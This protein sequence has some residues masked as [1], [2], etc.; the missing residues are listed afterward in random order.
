MTRLAATLTTMLL[1]AT[2]LAGHG[3]AANS[4]T[5][6]GGHGPLFFHKLGIQIGDFLV[7]VIPLLLIMVPLVRLAL[8]K[9]H[10]A[11]VK[12]I[13][14]ARAVHDAATARLEAAENHMR[15]IETEMEDIRRSFREMGESERKSFEADAI[16]T[17]QKM[18]REAEMRINQAGLAMQASLTGDLVQRA[19]DRVSFTLRAEGGKPVSA[20]V[21][22]R[23]TDI[24]D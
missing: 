1:S 7:V 6:H 14:E 11:V 9:R 19:L 18:N 3:Q 4:A 24:D 10:H 15:H 20:D 2:A 22:R 5:H 17:I 21:V 12:M 8:R 23:L 13:D 16:A